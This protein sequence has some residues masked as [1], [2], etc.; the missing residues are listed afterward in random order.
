MAAAG[1]QVVNVIELQGCPTPLLLVAVAAKGV[2]Q[3]C[4][5]GP[6]I[7]TLYPVICQN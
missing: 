4:A 3:T 7:M 6:V 5:I 1:F 2:D